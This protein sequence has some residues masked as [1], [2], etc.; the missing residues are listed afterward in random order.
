MELYRDL[1]NKEVKQFKQW[2]RDNYDVKTKINEA[3]HPT[4]KNEC[5][6]MIKELFK[7][8]IRDTKFFNFQN[9]LIL[10]L[11]GTL[12]EITKLCFHES[13]TQIDKEIQVILIDQS[14]YK[15]RSKMIRQL[16]NILQD[17]HNK[18]D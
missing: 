18:R 13:Y 3:W 17:Y 16:E 1:N 10:N 2:A 12:E 8:E 6:L 15:R 4:V 5:K 9:R 11:M 7:K 14:L